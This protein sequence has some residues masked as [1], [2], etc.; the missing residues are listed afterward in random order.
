[1]PTT[2]MVMAVAAARGFM[3]CKTALNV[4][5]IRVRVAIQ[6]KTRATAPMAAFLWF[7]VLSH[8]YLHVQLGL[9]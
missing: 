5:R 3:A 6:T 2:A 4:D 1:M 8:L 9:F 7:T